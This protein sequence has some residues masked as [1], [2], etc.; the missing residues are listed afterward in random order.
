[1]SFMREREIFGIHQINKERLSKKNKAFVILFSSKKG[2][3]QQ[4][5]TNY[6]TPKVEKKRTSLST[7]T[8][9]AGIGNGIAEETSAE[10]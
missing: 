9:T 8:P 7:T 6:I 5:H 10:L 2:E 4:K 3:N 1:M